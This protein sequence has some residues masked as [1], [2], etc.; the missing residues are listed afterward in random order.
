MPKQTYWNL[1]EAAAWVMYR[2]MAIVEQFAPPR[3][4]DWH[5]FILF[6]PDGD[7]Y[8]RIAEPKAL[9]A[10]LRSGDL[11]AY[12]RHAEQGAR[13]ERIPPLEWHDLVEEPTGPYRRSRSG[14]MEFPWQNIMVARADVERQWRR[15][16]E[17]QGRTRYRWPYLKEIYVELQSLHTEF[18]QNDLIGELQKEYEARTNRE[19]PS[20]TSIQRHLKSW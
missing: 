1:M 5:A 11:Q 14:A 8:K 4:N 18:S 6:S 2:D 12:G 19:P 13:M 15:P 10:A 9:F 3:P 20:R 17:T 7:G 16:A